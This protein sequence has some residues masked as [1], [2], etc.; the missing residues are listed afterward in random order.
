MH[1]QYKWC[2][3]PKPIKCY[4][5]QLLVTSVVKIEHPHPGLSVLSFAAW[6]HSPTCDLKH[7]TRV[8]SCRT[9]MC[10]PVVAFLAAPTSQTLHLKRPI[11][12][13]RGSYVSY[14]G[15]SIPA[16]ETSVI[17]LR[18]CLYSEGAIPTLSLLVLF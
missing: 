13:V 11:S 2:K 5:F 12:T 17:T 9:S 6:P 14:K 1:K 8:P 10:L 18:V 15:C 7:C 4:I 16:L 3:L